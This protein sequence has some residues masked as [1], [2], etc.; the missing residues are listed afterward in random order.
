MVEVASP[1]VSVRLPQAPVPETVKATGWP[2]RVEAGVALSEVMVPGAA[3][4]VTTVLAEPV[5]LDVP[6]AVAVKVPALL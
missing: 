1:K 4:T 6:V 5:Q 3:V 2:T